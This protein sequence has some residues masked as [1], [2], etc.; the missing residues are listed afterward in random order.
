MVHVSVCEHFQ[1]VFLIFQNDGSTTLKTNVWNAS[2]EQS[3][4]NS[5]E[6]F[7]NKMSDVVK[8]TA[9]PVMKDSK[10]QTPPVQVP[11]SPSRER[12]EANTK[13]TNPANNNNDSTSTALIPTPPQTPQK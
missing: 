5:G 8:G 2:N 7:E 4:T 3:S 12:K 9:K 10:T 11:H 1:I 13:Q 6:H